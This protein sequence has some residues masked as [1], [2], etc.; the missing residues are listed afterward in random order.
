MTGEAGKL[1]E[2]LLLGFSNEYLLCT[3][4]GGNEDLCWV[5]EF[6]VA[7]GPFR[8][9]CSADFSGQSKV[10]LFRNSGNDTEG[11]LHPCFCV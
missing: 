11:P 5:V 1:F 8:G 6:C 9:K 4:A 10:W 3:Y 7:H 2:L